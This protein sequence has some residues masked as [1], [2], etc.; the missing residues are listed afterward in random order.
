MRGFEDRTFDA[1]FDGV[2]ARKLVAEVGAKKLV[3]KRV[4]TQ[5]F[6]DWPGGPAIITEVGHDKN[7]PEISFLVKHDTWRGLDELDDGIMGVFSYEVVKL[8]C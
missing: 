1:Q 2:S 6:G 7:A 4:M 3:G 8:I 5:K